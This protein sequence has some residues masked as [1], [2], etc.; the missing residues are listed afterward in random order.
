MCC[1]H[2]SVA[3]LQLTSQKFEDP[4]E[5]EDTVRRKLRAVYDELHERFRLLEEEFR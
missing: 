2:N 4:A 5:G 1:A 3:P